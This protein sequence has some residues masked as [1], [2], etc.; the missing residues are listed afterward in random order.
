[1]APKL[2]QAGPEESIG[3]GQFRAL[4]GA[5]Q[6]AE[7]VPEGEVFQ[8]ECGSGFEGRRRGIGQHMKAAEHDTDE[9]TE[10]TQAPCSHVVQ[11]SRQPQ[12]EQH[13]LAT[14]LPY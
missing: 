14:I 10:D 4:H 9:L 1:M 3:G 13:D 8:L 11:Y 12:S 2:T 7:L 5:A 6:D